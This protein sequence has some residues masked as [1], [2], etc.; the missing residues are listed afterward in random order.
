MRCIEGLGFADGVDV[1]AEGTE[2]LMVEKVAAVEEEGG[3]IHRREDR[4]VIE[5]FKLVPLR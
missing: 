4:W 3:A 2:L 1:E 5:L